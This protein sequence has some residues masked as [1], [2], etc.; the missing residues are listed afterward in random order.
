[1]D[2][3]YIIEEIIRTT[4]E[5]NGK[6]LGQDRFVKETGIKV[7]YFRGIYWARYSDAVK[8]AEC[9]PN[10]L[11]AAYDE[12]WLI[13]QLISLTRE[14]KKFPSSADI[15]LKSHNT[16][17]FPVPNTFTRLGT[18]IVRASNIIKYCES[19]SNYQDV[20]EIC[21]NY[22]NSSSKRKSVNN[23]ATKS[24][25]GY[26][27]LMKFGKYYKIGASK[28]VERRNYEIGIKLPEKFDII[29]KIK[30]DDES[31]IELYWHNRFKDKRK[32]GEWFDLLSSDIQAFKRR[33]FM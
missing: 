32:Q 33:K 27:Y 23:D 9:E 3:K 26:V 14:I 31:G 15:N 30:T 1:M 8:E 2:R 10:K 6:P 22:I 21:Q 25:F 19:K 4:K 13:E 17:N 16:P 24:E 7:T 20:I 18:T 12:S 28:N 29:H 5:N 11:Q